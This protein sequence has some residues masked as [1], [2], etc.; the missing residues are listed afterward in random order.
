MEWE[1][2]PDNL[3]SRIV[4]Y[5]NDV[6]P[7]DQK[8][9]PRQHEWLATRL[10]DLHRVFA[11]RIRELDADDWQADGGPSEARPKHVVSRSR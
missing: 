11:D 9:W 8:D 10:N 5:L 7:K 3:Y 1:E 6:D 2:L 4:A